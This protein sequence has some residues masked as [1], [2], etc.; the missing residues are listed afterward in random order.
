MNI[1]LLQTKTKHKCKNENDTS[2]EIVQTPAWGEA[3][4]GQTHEGGIPLLQLLSKR[5][6]HCE[7]GNDSTHWRRGQRDDMHKIYAKKKETLPFWLLTG[8]SQSGWKL[9]FIVSLLSLSSVTMP[10]DK[11]D[12]W[13]VADMLD[14]CQVS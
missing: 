11:H 5:G 4:V 7:G 10:T 9:F 8:A 14:C 3:L 13:T 12:C 1:I 2:V 6:Q